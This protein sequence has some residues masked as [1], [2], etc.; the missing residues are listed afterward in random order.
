MNSTD[1]VEW[2]RSLWLVWL[3]PLFAVVVWRAHRPQN[4]GRFG[5]GARVP[6]KEGEGKEDGR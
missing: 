3:V 6:L 1:I 4:K 2:L 5:E